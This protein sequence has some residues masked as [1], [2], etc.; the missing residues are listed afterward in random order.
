[1]KKTIAGT[2]LALLLAACN[3][4]A[5]HR[6]I[7]ATPAP[8]PTQSGVPPL[9]ITGRG[10]RLQPVRI[11]AQS[12]NRKLYEL[13]AQSYVSNAAQAGAQAVF[14]SADVTFFAA[15]G[16]TMQARA[17]Q[18]TVDEHRKA[19]TMTGGVHAV[20][21]T[22]STL[23]CDRLRYERSTGTITGDGNVRITGRQGGSREVLMGNH[24]VSDVTLTRMTMR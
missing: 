5:P 24:F 12:G 19:V 2:A 11:I 8:S 15:G 7:H 13:R 16:T 4:Q 10:T 6:L 3:P 21:S 14:S 18:A 9:Q 20:T 17:P 23:T 1:V 22:G